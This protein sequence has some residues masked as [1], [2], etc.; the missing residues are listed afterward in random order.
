MDN[1]GLTDGPLSLVEPCSEKD[2]LT[3]LSDSDSGKPRIGG[4][5]VQMVM[6]A[7]TIT[8][9]VTSA[10]LFSS[11]QLTPATD[12]ANSALFRGLHLETMAFRLL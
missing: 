6:V 12:F 1:D 4:K 8:N 11:H 5:R 7:P 3:Q 2:N 9:F 10:V